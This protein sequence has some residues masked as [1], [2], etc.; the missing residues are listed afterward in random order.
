MNPYDELGN[1]LGLAAK[2]NALPG[3]AGGQ[4]RRSAWSKRRPAFA[5]AAVAVVAGI[6]VIGSDIGDGRADPVKAAAAVLDADG[7]VIHIVFEGGPVQSDGRPAAS[8]LRTKGS[9]ET[10]KFER[11]IEQWST[12]DPLRFRSTQNVS[13]E[14]GTPVG[15]YDNGI[16]PGGTVWS[17][18]SWD[19][20]P[21]SEQ[22]LKSAAP[23]GDGARVGELETSDPTQQ[24]R[25]DLAA[26]RMRA[27]GETTVASRPATRLVAKTGSG[28]QERST[29]YLVD[30]TTSAPLEVRR[31]EGTTLTDVLTVKAFDTRRLDGPAD[32][33]FRI[34]GR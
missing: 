32:A 7:R 30:S 3:A 19:D 13:T 14:S 34:P 8:L 31:Y 26:G 29:V 21:A 20:Q 24:I 2:D 4:V 11:R 23:L 15:T 17:D 1:Q 12:S 5:L 25:A 16:T 22:S 27:D 33:V 9:S 6:A 28:G 18:M 10:V